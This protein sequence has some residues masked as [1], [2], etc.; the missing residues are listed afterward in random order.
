L[1]TTI[2]IGAPRHTFYALKVQPEARAVV[3]DADGHGGLVCGELFVQRRVACRN[4]SLLAAVARSNMLLH[5]PLIV[6]SRCTR[7]T[8]L[9]GLG[10]A[11]E[12]CEF[13]LH[14]LARGGSC[15]LN[16]FDTVKLALQ[17]RKL[18]LLLVCHCMGK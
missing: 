6:L 9:E 16:Q 13:A 8:F 14:T 4:V 5:A 7:L 11:G 10:L 17:A 18:L 12:S 2:L 3:L 15:A 1:L